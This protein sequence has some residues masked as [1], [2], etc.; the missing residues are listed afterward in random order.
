[1]PSEFA[2]KMKAAKAAKA[3]ER[4]AEVPSAPH[5]PN[6]LCQLDTDATASAETFSSEAAAHEELENE[7][8]ARSALE[9]VQPGIRWVR[10]SM[11]PWLYHEEQIS[12]RDDSGYDSNAYGRMTAALDRAYSHLVTGLGHKLNPDVLPP[13]SSGVR[14]RL[15]LEVLPDAQAE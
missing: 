14:F 13:F 6:T 5:T 4:A 8:H 1:M 12:F 2:E 9:E 3:A 15:V 7:L 11:S 10:H